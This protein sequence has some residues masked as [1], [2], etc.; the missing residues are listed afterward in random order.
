M[1]KED[2]RWAV[3]SIMFRPDKSQ[4]IASFRVSLDPEA[5]PRWTSVAQLRDKDDNV[6]VEMQNTITSSE[7]CSTHL[8]SIQS[9]RDL[10]S[11]HANYNAVAESQ[12]NV[13]VADIETVQGHGES[14]LQLVL[15]LD[16]QC[17]TR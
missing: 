14:E 8:V 12:K 16:R 9:K 1:F 13:S 3:K 4:G 2:T 17:R 15:L 10:T 5:L 11:L 6:Q 7:V